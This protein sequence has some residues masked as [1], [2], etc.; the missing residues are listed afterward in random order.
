MCVACEGGSDS[1][2]MLAGL[3]LSPAGWLPQGGGWDFGLASSFSGL[4]SIWA[5]DGFRVTAA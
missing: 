4:F 5:G 1:A 2:L 3:A